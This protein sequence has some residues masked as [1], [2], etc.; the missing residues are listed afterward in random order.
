MPPL[1]LRLCCGNDGMDVSQFELEV[2]EE[3]LP[4]LD[5][6]AGEDARAVSSSAA[7][8]NEVAEGG[9]AGSGGETEMGGL[10]GGLVTTAPAR[11]P[12]RTK[13]VD[14]VSRSPPRLPVLLDVERPGDQCSCR[15]EPSSPYSLQRSI[16][17][18]VSQAFR[19]M[20]RT[21]S[22][23]AAAAAKRPDFAGLWV[24][25][26]TWGLDAF[27][28]ALGISK[29]RRIAAAKAPWPTW[30]FEQDED[31]FVF[32]NRN[33]MGVMREEFL[34]GGPEYTQVDGEKQRV[35]SRAIWEDGQLVIER[36]GP[37]GRFREER[38]L[39]ESGRRLHFTLRGFKDG[40]TLAWGRTF[41]RKLDALSSKAA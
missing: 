30:E 24:C 22:G 2:Q 34:V 19:K 37:K 40:N 16:S 23:G 38:R 4:P 11:T 29:L 27:L 21:F 20:S 36:T 14:E 7:T 1:F 18:G 35:C 3:Q 15:K 5:V 9:V 31:A 17:G 41:A 13:H 8:S 6:A 39:D 33:C 12:A 28:Q 26:S 10:R 32:I 25:T